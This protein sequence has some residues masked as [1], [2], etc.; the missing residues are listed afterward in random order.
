MIRFGFYRDG[1]RWFFDDP[2]RGIVRE[3]MVD[4]ADALLDAMAE[5]GDSVVADVDVAPIDGADAVLALE[6]PASEAEGGIGTW[7]RDEASGQR[8]W[9]CPTLGAYFDPPPPRIWAKR[10]PGERPLGALCLGAGGLRQCGSCLH[11]PR[12]GAAPAA[13]FAPRRTATG[14]E[15]CRVRLAGS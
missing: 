13:R 6:G 2:A 8:A 3:E 10:A 9:L 1:G 12:G 7:Y 14:C 4:G 15:D 5:G 11:R